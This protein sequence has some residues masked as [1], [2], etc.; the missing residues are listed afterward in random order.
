MRNIYDA[1]TIYV[2]FCAAYIG[3]LSIFGTALL[4]LLPKTQSRRTESAI[5]L[6]NAVARGDLSPEDA[7]RRLLAQKGI[8]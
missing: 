4:S 7:A 2:S 5:E 1:G 6:F 8:R 3:L